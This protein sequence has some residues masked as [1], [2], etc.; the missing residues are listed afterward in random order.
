M[1]RYVCEARL[2]AIQLAP[3][4]AVVVVG[5]RMMQRLPVLR[6]NLRH[7]RAG[8]EAVSNDAHNESKVAG[9]YPRRA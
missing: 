4:G 6:R 9:I 5:H 7:R 8:V 1:R 3:C 2:R